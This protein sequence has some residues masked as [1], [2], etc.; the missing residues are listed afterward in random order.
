MKTI[1]H[2]VTTGETKEIF[3]E[4]VELDMWQ[5]KK[6]LFDL[7]A[8]KREARVQLQQL[9]SQ[10]TPRRTREAILGTDNGWLADI[11]SQI[12]VLRTQL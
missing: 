7:E 4:G 3:L 10:I 6:R 1:E 9:E 2:N 12:A 5:E 8:P 11:E